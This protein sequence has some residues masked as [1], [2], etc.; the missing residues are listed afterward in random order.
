MQSM[1]AC[2]YFNGKTYPCAQPQTNAHQCAA[3]EVAAVSR[4]VKTLQPT[5][6][7]TTATLQRQWQPGKVSISCETITAKPLLP[8]TFKALPTRDHLAST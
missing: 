4:R 1:F 5:C 2:I 8:V 3:A 7:S 6:T